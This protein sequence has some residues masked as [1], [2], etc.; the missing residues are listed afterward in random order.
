MITWDSCQRITEDTN[1]HVNALMNVND[2][3]IAAGNYGY[4]SVKTEDWSDVL[5]HGREYITWKDLAVNDKGIVTAVGL[6]GVIAT[7]NQPDQG[8]SFIELSGELF[9]NLMAVEYLSNN[10]FLCIGEDAKYFILDSDGHNQLDELKEIPEIENVYAAKRLSDHRVIISGEGNLLGITKDGYHWDTLS[11]PAN[12]FKSCILAIEELPGDKVIVAG[13]HGFYSIVDSITKEVL[14][15]GHIPDWE[16]Q[17]SALKFIDRYVIAVGSYGQYNVNLHGLAWCKTEQIPGWV[18]S[19]QSIEI[20]DD[21]IIVAGD[22]GQYTTG[23][24]Q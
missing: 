16:G 2:K 12:P 24:L 4:F 14:I 19:I 8:W 13:E 3:I 11:I 15:T 18:G 23:H 17:V 6:P 7:T 22:L 1:F 5:F 21:E 9:P 10:T 20:Q